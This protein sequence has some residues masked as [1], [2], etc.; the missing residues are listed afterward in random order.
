MVRKLFQLVPL[1]PLS[2]LNIKKA[3]LF[4]SVLKMIAKGRRNDIII[5][6][7]SGFKNLHP[8]YNATDIFRNSYHLTADAW[9]F[10]INNTLQP[11]KQIVKYIWIKSFHPS[12]ILFDFYYRNNID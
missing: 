5:Y 10:F 11:I 3:F 2:G 9:V 6:E 12:M 4:A 1:I 7:V 8:K